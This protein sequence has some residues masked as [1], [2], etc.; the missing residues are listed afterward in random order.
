VKWGESTSDEMCTCFFAYTLDSE[1]LAA[2]AS[3]LSV[4]TVVVPVSGK[5]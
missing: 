2:P 5:P 3:P 1:H 4:E